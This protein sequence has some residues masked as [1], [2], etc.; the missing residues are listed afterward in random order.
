MVCDNSFPALKYAYQHFA[1]EYDPKNAMM[2]TQ[3]STDGHTSFE[4]GRRGVRGRFRGRGYNERGGHSNRNHRASFSHAGP[5]GDR[6]ITTVVVEQIP[7][8]KFNE[9][10][11]REF[12]SDF[13][14]IEKVDMQAYKRLAI[15]KYDDYY[16]AKRAYDSPKVIFDNRFVKVY[17]YKPNSVPQPPENGNGWKGGQGDQTVKPDEE[18]IDP[19]EFERKQGEAQKAYEEKLKKLKEAESQREE[20][21]KKLKMQAEERKRLLE[22]LSAK[23]VEKGSLSSPTA[24]KAV[25]NSITGATAD[26]NEE[27]SKTSTQTEALKKKLAELE[28]EAESMGINP[29]DSYLGNGYTAERGRGSSRG[30]GPSF[31]RGRGNPYRGSPRG[32][33]GAFSGPVRGGAV[34]R[35]DN[36]TKR[37]A[38]SGVEF[39]TERDEAL[40]QHL[41]VGL[42]I[43]AKCCYSALLK[44]FWPY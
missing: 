41:F 42:V 29:Q 40:R 37:V 33:R 16:S 24:D 7:E 21:D 14:K 27:S 30:R 36:R 35:L 15:V 19:A 13:G 22:K 34:K 2:A 23:A 6:S 26:N 12:F 28:A 31:I 25:D 44:L 1:T 11:V 17:W 10:T 4:R 18:M 32:G 38:V 8:E 9:Q 5:N 43:Q 39:G 20:L 3:T